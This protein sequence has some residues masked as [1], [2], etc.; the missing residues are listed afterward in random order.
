MTTCLSVVCPSSMAH[1]P[2]PLPAM[3]AA[4]AYAKHA[5]QAIAL[6]SLMGTAIAKC[7]L[8][9]VIQTIRV[10]SAKM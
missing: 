6:L 3:V 4:P 9:Y 7:D 2:E 1:M 5:I 10:S 8:M